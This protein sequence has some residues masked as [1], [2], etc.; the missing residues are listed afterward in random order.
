[1]LGFILIFII[2]LIIAIVSES[3]AYKQESY[4][5]ITNLPYVDVKGDKGRHLEYLTYKS[6]RHFENDGGKFLF[7]VLIPKRNGE[8]TEI[9]VILICSKGLFIFECK[10][11]SGWIFG[12]EL[13]KKWT[14]TLPLG[15]GRCQKEQFYN[16]IMQNSSHIRHLKNLI[17]KNLPMWS[18]VVFS[19]R[20]VFKDVTI[21]SDV[22]VI[23]HYET[24]A[25]VACKCKQLPDVYRDE[26]INIIYNQLYP[27][28]KN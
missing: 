9:D 27:Y 4:Y 22:R 2:I 20:C 25:V 3:E 18:I 5:Q 14:Q 17:G 11:F 1:M 28:T 24:E 15:R 6:L 16:P 13:Q 12:N 8:T 26:E 21:I 23:N 7:N 10:N 19:D